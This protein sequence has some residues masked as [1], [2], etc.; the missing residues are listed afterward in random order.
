MK[1]IFVALDG[2][3]ENS[4]LLDFIQG[5]SKMTASEELLLIYNRVLRISLPYCDTIPNRVI[6]ECVNR[7]MFN[8]LSNQCSDSF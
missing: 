2:G 8:N 7:H 4:F 3:V 1:C 5:V 6:Q